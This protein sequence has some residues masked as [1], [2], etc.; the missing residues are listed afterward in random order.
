M[1]EFDTARGRDIFD[2]VLI[3]D[4]RVQENRGHIPKWLGVVNVHNCG[5]S[6]TAQ[7]YRPTTAGIA[8][9]TKENRMF[10]KHH[11]RIGSF[12]PFAIVTSG[13]MGRCGDKL[14]QLLAAS[15]KATQF[16]RVSVFKHSFY[17]DVV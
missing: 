16:G 10:A 9:Q 13:R 17:E 11:P 7:H 6:R 4:I 12:G 15:M 14:I 5:L 1:A 8:V 2:K 3:A